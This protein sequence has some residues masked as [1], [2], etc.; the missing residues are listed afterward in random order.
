MLDLCNDQPTNLGRS[1]SVT[2]KLAKNNQ[3]QERWSNKLNLVLVLQSLL[4]IGY[5]ACYQ[6]A[7]MADPCGT[8]GVV[9]MG[10]SGYAYWLKLGEF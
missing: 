8:L 2:T 4:S 3:D 7:D 9:K 6:L 5:Y 1:K 10:K